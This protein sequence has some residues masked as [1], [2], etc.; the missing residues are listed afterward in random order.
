MKKIEATMEESTFWNDPDAARKTISSL[1]PLKL[2][3]EPFQAVGARLDDVKA[4]VELASEDGGEDFVAEVETGVN[5]LRSEVDTLEFKAMMTEPVDPC[6]AIV[7]IQAG[8]GG[9][10]ACDWAVMLQRMYRMWSEKHHYKLEEIDSSP[11]ETAGLRNVTFIVKG[12][13]AFGNLRAEVG[14]H[15]LVRISPFD[16]NERRQTSFVSVDVLPDIED[17][18]E[19]EIKDGDLRI[20]TF[21]AGGPGGQHQNK[22]Q[23]G[24]RVT[25]IP[26]GIAAESRTERSQHQNKANCMKM[27][28]SRMYQV[29]KDKRDAELAKKYEQK[30]EIAF[31]S[32]IR[33]YVLHPYQLVKDHRTNIESGN[34][35]A[36]LD[37]EIDDFIKGY[38]RSQIGGS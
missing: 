38:L 15:R 5:L 6:H 22:T 4:S 28:R 29:E 31:G 17:E 12:D 2:A 35:A 16:A 24:V 36:V 7:T 21:S 8:A 3:I 30:S 19:I 9:T 34:T 26:T 14:V 11:G 27:L 33:S 25:H 18:I 10:D 37:G 13:Y 1:K 23:S 32:Q 20:D